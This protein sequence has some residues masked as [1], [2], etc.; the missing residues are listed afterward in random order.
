MKNNTISIDITPKDI[1]KYNFSFSASGRVIDE[2]AYSA[3]QWTEDDL[4]ENNIDYENGSFDYIIERFNFENA[5]LEQT[6]TKDELVAIAELLDTG[7]TLDMKKTKLQAGAYMALKNA[8]QWSELLKAYT[9][10]C[11]EEMYSYND[12]EFLFKYASTLQ[13]ELADS[14]SD[15]Y[16]QNYKEWLYGDHRDYAGV[17]RE[18]AKYWT[19][20]RDNGAYDE[21]TDVYT[22]T[23]DKETA[24]DE[25]EQWNGGKLSIKEYK[26]YL[27]GRMH[28]ACNGIFEAKRAENRKRK[29]ESE[30]QRAYKA[31]QKAKAEA[32]RVAELKARTL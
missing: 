8:G 31:E 27:L 5:L 25:L 10:K 20:D 1:K 12:S 2:L 29:E 26:S 11:K 3:K 21:K 4:F 19:E 13:K 23:I 15:F 16:K 7:A 30:R 9:D 17:I 28:D 22:F 24:K 18:I 14:V 32:D 6:K